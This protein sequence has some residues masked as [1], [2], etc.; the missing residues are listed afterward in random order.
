MISGASRGIGAAIARRL[1]ADGYRLSLGVRRPADGDATRGRMTRRA[2]DRSRFDALE[3][4]TARAVARRHARTVR[5]ARR[6]RS[7]MP[8]SSRH[9]PLREG[10]EA[11]LDE[12]W[13][14]NVKAPFR[15]I[16]LALPHLREERATAGSS[17]S[18]RPTP[19]AIRDATVSVGYAM[20]KHA[21]LALTPCGEIRGLGRRRARHRALP[22]RRG[23]RPHRRPPRRH[24]RRQPHPARDR[25]RTPSASC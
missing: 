1:H 3:P 21:V 6:A 9:G 10:D 24:A 18:P 22:G 8:A 19:S 25:R 12:M 7:T 2:S 17:T 13:A 16:R 11:A 23:H 15:L 20:T 14:V 4:A 5:P